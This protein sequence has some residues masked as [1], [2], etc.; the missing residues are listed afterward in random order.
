MEGLLTELDYFSPQ[1]L[2]LSI[3]AEYDRPFGIGLTI[4][5]GGPIEFFIR[6]A[7]NLYLDLNNSK[8]E[9][10]VKITLENGANIVAAD[11]VGPVNDLLNTLFMSAEMELGS[12]MVTDPNTKYGFR[13][14]I[15]N[16]LSSTKLISETRMVAEGWKKDT[17]G[18]MNDADTAGANTG[19]TAR[20]RWFALSNVV[21]L[22]GRPHLDLF[23][24]EKLIPPGID[25]K[26]RFIP[27]SNTFLLKTAAPADA[28][29]QVMYKL[30]IESAKL[31]IRTKEISPSLM[32]AHQKVLQ[33]TN[34]SITYNQI[35]TKVVSI[36]T[37]TSAIEF[38][39]VF[40]GKLPDIVV[41]AMISDAN[42]TGGYQANPFNF[43]NFGVNF[44]CIQA[45]G[46]QI[47]RIP[48]QPNFANNDYIRA[49][50]G[51]LEALGYDIGPNCWE[52]TPEE[53][54]TGYNIYAFKLTAGPIG[55]V[56]TPPRVGSARLEIK[57]ANAS[58]TNINVLLL[59][60]QS[61]EIQIDKY[62]NVILIN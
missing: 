2:Q 31:F 62:K 44:L 20:T 59:S 29:P 9:V 24:Q 33:D 22:I 51:I 35:K 28:D 56:R 37:G 61:A 38:D 25:M 7:D 30:H 36:P 17:S 57:F 3:N 1:V 40:Q 15:E 11:H 16:L 53:W 8:L 32:T 39:N 5:Q 12:T 45:N 43:E 50:F 14:I 47:P 54:A 19:L 52:L 10:K 41:L 27:N 60:Q 23:H 48:Y 26:L 21:T 49:Y 46:E 18:H 55:T 34:Y 42:M 58:T 13:A 6:G 4:V